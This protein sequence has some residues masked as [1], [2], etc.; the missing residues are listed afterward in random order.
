LEEVMLNVRDCKQMLAA[1]QEATEGSSYFSVRQESKGFTQ[2]EIIEAFSK[3]PDF[4]REAVESMVGECEARLRQNGIKTREQLLQLT[5]AEDA[6]QWV[7]EIYQKELLRP[8]AF[9]LDPLAVATWVPQLFLS[10]MSSEVQS[11]IRNALI[12][13]QEYQ[14]VRAQR[15][16][17]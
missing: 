6:L 5:K 7:R 8:S 12:G 17:K 9:P 2:D 10:N 3:L 11:R 15:P 1:S 13:C 14:E 16:A 4:S